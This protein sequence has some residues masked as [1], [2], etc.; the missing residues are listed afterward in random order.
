MT[1]DDQY[2][3]RIG[4]TGTSG[5]FNA[6]HSTISNNPDQIPPNA[7]LGQVYRDVAKQMGRDS[8]MTNLRGLNTDPSFDAMRYGHSASQEIS[9]RLASPDTYTD[10]AIVGGAV[11]GATGNKKRNK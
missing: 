3:P 2:G 7:E 10:P 8:M 5:S 11:V 1:R 9:D 6:T 4:D